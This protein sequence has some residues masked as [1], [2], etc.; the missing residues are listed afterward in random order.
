[1]AR[2]KSFKIV[3]VVSNKGGCGKSLCA[4]NLAYALKARGLKVGILDADLDSPYLV[5]IT[6]AKG[7]I[8]LDANRQMI[9]VMHDGMPLMSFALWVPTQFVGASMPGM[10]H[11]RWIADA[12]EHTVWGDIDVLVVDLPAGLGDEYL[13]VARVD[14][15]RRIGMVVVGLPQVVS[16]L[17]RVYETASYHHLRILGVIENMAGGVFGSGPI[18][19]FCKEK[20]L[21]FLGSIPLDPRIRENHEAHNPLI[22]EDLQAPIRAACDL[23]IARTVKA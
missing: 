10:M 13:T 9:P 21:R 22:P 11:E 20:G 12:L 1:M 4:T 16:G 23:I 8:N 2:G 15:S 7:N 18:E 17:K 6:G 14:A 3:S 5:E 19:A